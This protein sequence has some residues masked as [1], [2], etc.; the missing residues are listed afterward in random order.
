[1]ATVAAGYVGGAAYDDHPELEPD[2][3]WKNDLRQKIQ[4]QLRHLVDDARQQRDSQ[5]IHHPADSHS[6]AA[7]DIA[8][9]K[10]QVIMT[11][12]RRLAQDQYEEALER[13]RLERR[14]AAGY[15]V[16]QSWIEA[17]AREQ[18]AMLTAVH[19]GRQQT[20]AGF[21]FKPHDEPVAGPSRLA[22]RS[23]SGDGSV[24]H[25]YSRFLEYELNA[26]QSS[27][28]WY[29]HSYGEGSG[30]SSRPSAT[31]GGPWPRG[32]ISAPNDSEYVQ[33]LSRL[34]V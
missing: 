16:D 14:W 8:S 30:E 9:Q 33:C 19:N 4:D 24:S 3:Q 12:I 26:R 2:L 34:R 1:M 23:T 32:G 15:P 22:G 17:A 20:H 31:P 7:N 13:E 10:Y 18:E 29:G 28:D 21:T 25:H 11:D 6:A 27:T 5:W